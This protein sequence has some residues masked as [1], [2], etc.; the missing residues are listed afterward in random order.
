MLKFSTKPLEISLHE[1]MLSKWKLDFRKKRYFLPCNVNKA[2]KNDDSFQQTENLLQGFKI[3]SKKQ[4]QNP[5]KAEVKPIQTSSGCF[6]NSLVCMIDIASFN[7]KRSN[8]GTERCLHVEW[9][10][11]QRDNQDNHWH[12]PKFS[13]FITRLTRLPTS[14]P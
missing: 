1:K 4:Q 14:E 2:Y 9:T 13:L 3:L 6:Y 12:V 11:K 10:Q 8:C 7:K 5:W